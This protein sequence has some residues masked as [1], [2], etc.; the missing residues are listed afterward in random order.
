MRHAF[1][2]AFLPGGLL[3][4][5]CAPL[6]AQDAPIPPADAQWTIYCTN[7]TGPNHVRQAKSLRVDLVHQTGMRDWYVVQGDTESKLFYGFYRSVETAVDPKE[8]KR[9]HG[10]LHAIQ[11]FAGASG[12]HPFARAGIVQIV[13]PDPD[14]PAD[15]N[16]VNLNRGK[17]PDDPS[18]AYY[19]LQVAAFRDSPERK[20]AAVD[21]VRE[22][23]KRGVEAYY[24]HGDTVSEVCIGAWPRSA[25]KEEGGGGGEGTNSDQPVVVFNTPLSPS[26]ISKIEE[27]NG[28]NVKVVAP[29]H[30]E[31]VDPSLKRMMD[32]YPDLYVNGD[33]HI[34]KVRNP[35]TNQV[36]MVPDRSLIVQVPESKQSLIDDAPPVPT[37][38]PPPPSLARPATPSGTGKLKSLDD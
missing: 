7:I 20:Q 32:Q 14:G 3:L 1:V 9:V 8:A 29:P 10:D 6:F 28:G 16:L 27:S 5:L 2:P 36:D 37:I 22:F 18:R 15:W 13:P 21:A 12:E 34:N 4:L 25:M 26:A 17:T 23:R 35:V 31:P 38:A 11:G 24:H 19:T 30:L 33:T